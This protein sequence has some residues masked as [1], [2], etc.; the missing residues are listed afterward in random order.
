MQLTILDLN[1][2]DED[3]PPL[4]K[5]LREP[6]GLL[7]V[8]GCLSKTRLLKAYRNGIFPWYNPEDPI[9][10]WSPDPRLVLFPDK[11]NVSRSL[12]KTL[13]KNIFSVTFDQAFKQ[14]INACGELRK[15]STGTWITD[16]ITEAY[17][18]L[19]RLGFAHS[20]ETW[21][22]GALVGGLYGVALGQVFFGESMFHSMTDASKVAFVRLVEQLKQWD[23][24]L[25]DCQVHTRHLE[26]LG[27][28]EIDRAY[29]VEL[30]DRYCD[31]PA[32][33]H[34]WQLQ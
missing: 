26:S 8:G 4:S 27:A 31:I 13:R 1:N 28:Q 12:R 34:A 15:N 32:N 25:I 11:L 6:D 21:H 23:Y 16:E 14:V 30:L 33:K 19:Y 24:Q 3:F 22:N 7:A 5:A 18:E 2:P 20:V 10:W 17:N 29:F 9:L